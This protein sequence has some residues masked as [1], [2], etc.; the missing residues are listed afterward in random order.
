MQRVDHP[1]PALANREA[2][3][4]LQNGATGLNLVFKGSVG[5]LGVE[6]LGF[7]LDATEA[8]IQSVLDGIYL[9]AG[10]A[11]ELD[12][13]PQ[14]KDA[15]RIL[16]SLVKTQGLD[17]AA[18]DIRFGFDPIGAM[19]RDGGTPVPWQQIVP[20]FN[21][22]ISDLAAQGFRGPFAPADGRVIHNAGGSEVQEL[23]YVL[24]VAV[25]YLRALESG[26]LSLDQARRMIFFRL[27]ADADQFLTIGKIPRAAKT[28]GARRGGLRPCARA[29]VRLRRDRVADDD[30]ARSAREHAAH[31]HRRVLG[32][33]RRRG[34]HHR[35]SVHRGA[36][37]A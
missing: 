2:L 20:I 32:R 7:G 24:A 15:G 17:P 9:D 8:T 29:G 12:L 26:G 4:E 28:L 1:D 5:D 19:A 31:D 30:A 33:H 22:A 23:A 6:G 16:A 35:A 36:R 10:V 34:C 25:E 13:S 21:A 37:L 11:I 3:H 27:S 18:T 14:S